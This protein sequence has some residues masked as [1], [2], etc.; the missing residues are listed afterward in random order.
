MKYH[1]SQDEI[2]IVLSCLTV[3][4]FSVFVTKQMWN[5]RRAMVGKSTR[6]AKVQLANAL[7]IT[8]INLGIP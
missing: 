8:V 6:T 1:F 5:F 7:M 2:F 3:G 4:F